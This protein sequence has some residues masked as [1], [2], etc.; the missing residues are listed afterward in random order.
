MG[1]VKELRSWNWRSFKMTFKEK[2]RANKWMSMTLFLFVVLLLLVGNSILE[3]R[4][5]DKTENKILCSVI[6]S[7]PAWSSNGKIISYGIIIPVN[8]STDII[9]ILLIPERIK[10]LYNPSCSACEQQITYFKEVGFWE[11][12]I[13]EGLVVDCSKE[14]GK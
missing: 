14:W 4:K 1:L 7:T 9:N 2:L 3:V 5:Q 10:F 13:K 11:D 8:Q 6:S 12:Y